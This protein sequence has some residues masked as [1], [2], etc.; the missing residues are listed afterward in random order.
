MSS[1]SISSS[2]RPAVPG[3]GMTA[4]IEPI[5]S[6]RKL[7]VSIKSIGVRGAGVTVEE[8]WGCTA[9]PFIEP[10]GDRS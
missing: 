5:E 10:G 2:E 4:L 3:T 6:L 9:C 7:S 8:E 1:P